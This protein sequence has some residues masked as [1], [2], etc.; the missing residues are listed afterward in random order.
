MYRESDKYSADWRRGK[1]RAQRPKPRAR[2]SAFPKMHNHIYTMNKEGTKDKNEN[3]GERKCAQRAEFDSPERIFR[4]L[5]VLG[6]SPGING[7]VECMSFD[8]DGGV[9]RSRMVS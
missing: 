7:Y 8:E 2:R 5:S 1:G 4:I 9:D 3:R 6:V